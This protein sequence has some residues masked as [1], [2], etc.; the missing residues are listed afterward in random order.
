MNK[1]ICNVLGKSTLINAIV[2]KQILPTDVLRTADT[3][4]ELQHNE[5]A[6]FSILEHHEDSNIVYPSVEFDRFSEKPSDAL[7]HILS[8]DAHNWTFSRCRIDYP[9]PLL[10]SGIVIHDSLGGK[11]TTE[12]TQVV[13]RNLKICHAFVYVLNRGLTSASE[14]ILQKLIDL[15]CEPS[16]MFFAVTHLE[17]CT[18]EEKATTIDRLREDLKKIDRRFHKCHIVI[19]DPR[20]ALEVFIKYNLYTLDYS[21]FMSHLSAFLGQVPFFKQDLISEHLGKTNY[22]SCRN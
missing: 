10:A 2:Q 18:V 4:I 12:L 11:D 13:V 20:R 17:D 6:S 16:S 9:L 22:D 1:I 5:N 21:E 19:I 3:I 8:H 7:K 15:Q 14:Q